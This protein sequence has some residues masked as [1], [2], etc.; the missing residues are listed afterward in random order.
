MLGCVKD[1]PLQIRTHKPN[2]SVL[3]IIFG[4]KEYMLFETGGTRAICCSD[5]AVAEQKDDSGAFALRR[6]PHRNTV[7]LFG[8]IPKTQEYTCVDIQLGSELDGPLFVEW[9]TSH[10]VKVWLGNNPAREAVFRLDE[11]DKA[12]KQ[13][14]PIP[15]DVPGV[16]KW[17]ADSLKWE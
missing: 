10:L 8:R 12:W 5:L 3:E 15:G 6:G 2:H 1:G 11:A 9:R 13:V 7:T 17:N 14:A 16:R 4:D